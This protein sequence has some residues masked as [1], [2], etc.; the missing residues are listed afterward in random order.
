MSRYYGKVKEFGSR[1][2]SK[3][4]YNETILDQETTIDTR[5]VARRLRL[6]MGKTME[7]T[8][9]EGKKDVEGDEIPP[10]EDPTVDREAFK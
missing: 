2:T 1:K 9:N 5:I 10:L 3:D 7:V 6:R 8:K 4:V